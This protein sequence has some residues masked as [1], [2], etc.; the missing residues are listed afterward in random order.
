MG[1]WSVSLSLSSCLGL[2]S[3]QERRKDIY[4]RESVRLRRLLQSHVSDQKSGRFSRRQRMFSRSWSPTSL[5]F[6]PVCRRWVKQ[7]FSKS[8]FPFL[9]KRGRGERRHLWLSV[10]DVFCSQNCEKFANLLKETVYI[11]VWRILIETVWN[12]TTFAVT[13][14]TFISC[15]WPKG[16]SAT[17]VSAIYHDFFYGFTLSGKGRVT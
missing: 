5:R 16:H 7:R 1:G 3:S 10:R 8:Q 4:R 2:E 11:L 17:S 12:V 15:F 14:Q 13:Q 6:P 9:Q